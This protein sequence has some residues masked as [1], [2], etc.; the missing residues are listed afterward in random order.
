MLRTLLCSNGDQ[1]MGAFFTNLHV[2]VASKE[3]VVE[4]LKFRPSYPVYVSACENEWVS[5]FPDRNDDQDEVEIQSMAEDLSQELA[6]P[7]FAFTVHDSDIFCYWFYVEGKVRDSFNSNPEYFNEVSEESKNE[8]TGKPERLLP[9]CRRGTTEDEIG[10][11]LRGKVVFEE[12]RVTSLA[13]L[14]GIRAEYATLN[15]S[16]ISESDPEIPGQFTLIRGA[17]SRDVS[18]KRA[19]LEAVKSGRVAV[20]KSL[21]EAG[22]SVH[23]KYPGG[24][25]LGYAIASGNPVMVKLL[26]DH[27][28]DPRNV[29]GDPAGRS[30]LTLAAWSGGKGEI[31]E[32]LAKAGGDVNKAGDIQFSSNGKV[33]GQVTPLMCAARF[34]HVDSVKTLLKLGADPEI[35]DASGKNAWDFA[36]EKRAWLVKHLPQ[37][38][39]PNHLRDCLSKVEQVIQLLPHA[40]E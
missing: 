16:D 40:A 11:T 6:K 17:A 13:N 25:L 2:Q 10:K 27:G 29:N 8:V 15:F 19:A 12:N 36:A 3:R 4:A 37:A 34:H 39:N 18:V 21:I 7:V 30:P 32:Q 31:I 33:V 9:Y 22:T 5:V 38:K 35:K 26:L 28:A 14:L 1:F 24:N 23:L 20:L